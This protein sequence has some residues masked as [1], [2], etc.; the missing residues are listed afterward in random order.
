KQFERRPHGDHNPRHNG[1]FFMADDNWHHLEGTYERGNILRVYFY[2]DFTRPIAA[3]AFTA[4]AVVKD[5]SDL[6]LESVPMKAGRAANTLET[7]LKGRN[8]PLSVS[9]KV[10]FK[11]DDR[12]RTFDF[13]FRDYSNQPAPPTRTTT[14]QPTSPA[15]T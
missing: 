1:Q 14:A 3:R 10:R 2:D 15:P 9:L 8:L 7:V 11:P 13:A 5:Q 12:E 4:R 6:E